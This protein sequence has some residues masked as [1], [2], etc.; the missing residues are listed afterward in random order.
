MTLFTSV[1]VFLMSFHSQAGRGGGDASGGGFVVM[2]HS[3]GVELLDLV[4][5]GVVSPRDLNYQKERGQV[6]EA[7]LRR[8]S[9]IPSD[10]LVELDYRLEKIQKEDLVLATA[11]TKSILRMSWVFT[12]FELKSVII[13][14][15]P[16]QRS[17]FQ[18]AVRKPT[19]V[20]I[21]LNLWNK[22][23]SFQRAALI[24]HE[25]LMSLANPRL[26]EIR[27]RQLVGVF[28]Q[29]QFPV[30]ESLR[31]MIQNYFPSQS[32]AQ[33]K[34]K[35]TEAAGSIKYF[36]PLC[37]IIDCEGVSTAPEKQISWDAF[38]FP[39]VEVLSYESPSSQIFM[40]GYGGLG[41]LDRTTAFCDSTRPFRNAKKRVIYMYYELDLMTP[42]LNDVNLPKLD[43][44]LKRKLLATFNVDRKKKGCNEKVR[45]D[46]LS[47]QNW[48]Q[49]AEPRPGNSLF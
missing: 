23:D 27:I 15:T 6:F 3:G 44:T 28:F 37:R 20:Y 10:V 21:N 46:L 1:V 11:V 42:V 32:L 49:K 4:E 22:M 31:D 12:S 19:Q 48:F 2:N 41:A 47:F 43:F 18:V 8:L 36:P 38:L 9:W 24:V 45:S 34:L 7:V 39:H 29:N 5:S 30:P 40:L 35:L 13:A 14:D 17:L 16:Y 33:R 25:A 26:P